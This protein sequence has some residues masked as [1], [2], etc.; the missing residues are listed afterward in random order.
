M[1]ADSQYRAAVGYSSAYCAHAAF[2]SARFRLIPA[3]GSR[4]SR[5]KRSGSRI[6]AW[7]ISPSSIASVCRVWSM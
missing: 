5:A 1:L 2:P 6:A 7:M 3:G 4:K